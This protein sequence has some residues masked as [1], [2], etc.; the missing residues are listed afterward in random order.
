LHH[1]ILLLKLGRDQLEVLNSSLV[2]LD[3]YVH[4]RELSAQVVGLANGLV[5]FEDVVEFLVP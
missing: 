5:D 4:L 2:I 1:G 3:E